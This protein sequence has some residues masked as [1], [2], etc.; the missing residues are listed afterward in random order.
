MK[1][2]PKTAYLSGVLGLALVGA[3]VQADWTD[4]VNQAL[5]GGVASDTVADATLSN[6]QIV[7]G[8]KEALGDGVETSIKTLGR[9]N[10]F[11]TNDL[12]RIGI[13]DSL[14]PVE[15]LARQ[16]GQA[17]V[18]DEFIVTLNRAAEQAVPEAAAILGDAIRQLQL[19][20]ARAILNGPDDAATEY[21][22]RHSEARLRER[23][24]PIVRQTTDQVGVTS[25][26]KSLMKQAGGGLLGNF[27]GSSSLDL[28]NYVTDQALDGLFTYIAIQEREI[29][30][31]PAARTS[32]LLQQ[33]FGSGG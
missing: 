3:N 18:V 31:N 13:P 19:T 14:Q 8:L 25:A 1:I 6:S 16:A 29:R 30:E 7:A 22:Q 28:D 20:D 24:L 10:G 27:L 23:F 26:Y 21:F 32:E 2:N 5:Q 4:L 15:T 17:A 33:V 12:V 9:R 11:L